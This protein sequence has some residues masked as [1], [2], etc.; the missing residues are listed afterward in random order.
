MV[1]GYI[2]NLSICGKWG[3]QNNNRN[4][5]FIIVGF[6]TRLKGRKG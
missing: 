1:N 5:K 4:V 3:L 2:A 6:S